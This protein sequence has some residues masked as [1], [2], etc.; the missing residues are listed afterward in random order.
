[1]RKEGRPPVLPTST[2][3]VKSCYPFSGALMISE[4]ILIVTCWPCCDRRRLG[5]WRVIHS[6]YLMNIIC[7]TEIKSNEGQFL[8][9]LTI[10]YFRE[11]WM[12]YELF[13]TNNNKNSS[14]HNNNNKNIQRIIVQCPIVYF[15]DISFMYLFIHYRIAFLFLFRWYFLTLIVLWCDQDA[16]T[17]NRHAYN[18]FRCE[19]QASVPISFPVRKVYVF[20]SL[21][22]SPMPFPS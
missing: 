4:V 13:T 10:K 19:I 14:S 17:F 15:S 1:M 20:V 2:T 9:I 22:P 12:K 7:D 18:L 3:S 11:P 21:V 5:V 8:W 6:F 16:P